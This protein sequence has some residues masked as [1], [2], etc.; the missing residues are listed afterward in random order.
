[1]RS[2]VSISLMLAGLLSS[3]AV[4]RHL[5]FS[6]RIAGPGYP[7]GKGV[8]VAVVDNRT[9]VLNGKEKATWCGHTYSLAQIAYNIQT[10]T[11]RPVADEFADAI[12]TAY[13]SKGAHAKAVYA[14]PG[15]AADSLVRSQQPVPA[16]LWLLFDLRAWESKAVPGFSTIRYE[17]FYDIRLT[18]LDP[19]GKQLGSSEVHGQFSKE[20]GAV[21]SIATM[22]E[23]ADALL[24]EQVAALFD[25]ASVRNLLE[26]GR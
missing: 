9:A 18:V 3:C 25:A 13:T 20:G 17:H 10:K 26:A 23:M 1:M 22:Q 6:G 7:V 11:G 15:M 14:L 4:N 2:S 16:S 24:G 12:V 21:T 8:Q 5:N 19:A